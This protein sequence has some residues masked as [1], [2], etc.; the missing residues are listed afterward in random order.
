[1]VKIEFYPISLDYIDEFEGSHRGIIRLFGRTKK[2]K[3]ICVLD[4]G[5]SNYFWAVV[6]RKEVV[7]KLEEKILALKIQERRRVTY[8]TEVA[9]ERKKHLGQEVYALKIKV[10]NPR[11]IM[12]LREEIRNMEGV[13]DCLEIDIPF[14]HRYMRE[15]KID[16]LSLCEVEGEEI[17]SNYHSQVIESKS[18]KQI[19]EDILEKPKILSFDIEV[20]NV[21]RS[22]NDDEDPILMIAFCGND[23]FEKTIVWKKY[24]GA[25]KNVEFVKDERELIVKFKDVI[26]EFEP[27]YLV[28][29]FSDGFDFPY[30]RGRADKHKIKLDLGIDESNVKFS[31]GR[32]SK[33]A[34]VAGIAHIDIFKFVR[35]VLAGE[36]NLPSYD[37][38][39]VANNLLGTGKSGADV[40]NLHKAWDKGG[41]AIEEFC[42]YNLVDAKITLQLAEKLLPHVNEFIKLCRLLPEEIT[43]MSYGRLVENFVLNNIEQFDE[44][45]PNKPHSGTM[46]EREGE[47]IEGAFVYQPTAGL[48]ED[49]A[50]LDF[51]SLYPTIISAHNI[52]PSTL[53]DDKKDANKSPEITINGKNKNFYFTYKYDGIFPKLIREILVRRNRVKEM[54]KKN[55]KD[56]ILNA[57][58]YGLKILANSAYGYLGFFGARWYC[59]ECAASTTAYGRDYLKKLIER[60]KK[61]DLKVIYGD[62]DSVFVSLGEGK[63]LKDAERFLKDVNNDL[64]SLMELELDGFY[65]RGI[66]VMKKGD[67][68]KG[69][70]KKYALVDE[71]DNIKITGFET[72][73]GDWSK[74]AK[75][76]QE[77]VLRIIL[78]ENDVKKAVS[79]V[80]TIIEKTKN[81]KIPV[82]KMVIKKRLIKNIEEYVA[83]GPHVNVAKKL[84]KRGDVVGAG[85]DIF[86]VVQPGK[87]NIGNRA[88]PSDEAKIYD[89][90]YYIN[91]QII[92]VVERILSSVGYDKEDVT[93]EQKQKILGDF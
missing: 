61:D 2:G 9:L 28:G 44:I 50:V 17:E 83:I 79:Y 18:I 40:G 42:D 62:T 86:Y 13:K 71:E 23:G 68:E 74:I 87:G 33:T 72:V 56:A 64:P 91:H 43:R 66:F 78:V 32:G 27:D 5:F 59:K 89:P 45:A 21:R 11:D 93:N 10:N 29:Y 65:K 1:M 19:G 67:S 88:L 15:K 58:Q 34:K 31:K 82:E 39:T 3:R 52:C 16:A 57:R 81:G 6:E 41:K 30:I 20:Y 7:K 12:P 63:K 55:K 69:A 22:P 37:L 35:R 47:K 8:A 73:R 24:S 60:A 85:S 4:R 76:V 90:E 46:G 48:Y 54:L 84:V 77:K 38:D 51:K 26:R 25:K 36:L 70:K 92:P 14:V 75:E 80:K 53:T 49:V